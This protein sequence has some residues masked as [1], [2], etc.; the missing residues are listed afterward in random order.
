MPF[1]LNIISL[2]GQIFS[3]TVESVTV[4]AEKGRM[5]VLSDHMPIISPLV[6]GEVVVKG[7]E[8]LHLAIGKG[9]FTISGN[10]AELLVED[11]TRIEDLSEKMSLERKKQAEKVLTSDAD[12]DK[13]VQARYDLKKSDFELKLAKKYDKNN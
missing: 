9:I 10:R 13:K 4:P 8:D 7:S 6:M 2:K 3:G 12:E 1:H 5:T 11:D